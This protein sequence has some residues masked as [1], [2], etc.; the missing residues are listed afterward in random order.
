MEILKK[1]PEE[2]SYMR[3]DKACSIIFEDFSRTQHKKWIIQGRIL[4]NNELASPRDIVCQYDEIQI[5]PV[6]EKKTS[7]IAED[8]DFEIIKEKKDY[9]IINKPSN[10]IM[11][12]GAGCDVGTLANGLIYRFPELKNIP[13]VGIVHRLD[14]DTSGIVLVARTERFRNYFVNLLQERKVKKNYK[15]IVVGNI[16]G[17]FEIIDPIGRDKNNRIKMSIRPDGKEA[18]TFVKLEENYQNYSLLDI[19]IKTGRTHQ[20]RV[21]LSS[22]RLPIIGDNTYNPSKNIAKGTPASL[23]NIIRDFPR[24]ALHSHQ[25]S[26]EDPDSNEMLT[27]K[28]P[29]HEDMENLIKIL[30]KHI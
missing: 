8:I 19:S 24:Q 26:F 30:K 10:L 29:I 12:P 2:L 13:R 5:N 18:H 23:K 22:K 21:H 17:S 3:L 25:L 9:L 28:A 14:K 16:L 27:F 7:W 1:V 15:A 11:H 6:S 4:L 20:I